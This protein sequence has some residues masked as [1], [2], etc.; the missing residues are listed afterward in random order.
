MQRLISSFLVCAVLVGCSGVPPVSKAK[1]CQGPISGGIITGVNQEFDKGNGYQ[2]LSVDF[3]APRGETKTFLSGELYKFPNYY[4]GDLSL[5][6]TLCIPTALDQN[7][8]DSD[9][10]GMKY[11]EFKAKI[12]ITKSLPKGT[13]I[14][15]FS[16]TKDSWRT[17]S[18]KVN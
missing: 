15:V 5:V 4:R 14:L 18:F 8:V 13:Y 6:D 3:I 10:S 9:Q 17:N 11:S 12:S 16:T 2:F 7:G 1:T